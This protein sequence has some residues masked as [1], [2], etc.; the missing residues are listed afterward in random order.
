M[1]ILHLITDHQV[2]ERTLRVYEETFPGCNDV[3]VFYG[4]NTPFKHLEKD[5]KGKIVNYD[6]I[7]EI[8]GNIDFSNVTY[9][10]AHFMSM[11]KIDF[12]K[13]IP[14][15]IHV[16]WEIYGYDLY[17]QF[18]EPQ[19]LKLYYT[20][21]RKYGTLPFLRTYFGDILNLYAALRGVKYRLKR[22]IRKQFKYICNRINSIQCCCGY[23]AKFI[24]DYIKRD[25]PSYE[26][27]NYSLTEVL[28]EL[29][30]IDFFVGSDVLIGNS[31]S[32]SNNHL[33]TLTY[34]KKIKMPSSAKL[35]V[36]LSYG[37][38]PEY[39]NDVESAYKRLFPT[40]V[41]VL[42]EY[43]PLHDYNK[44][45]LRLRS[46]ILSA[47][48]QE[49]Q[50]TAMMGFYLGIKV[51]MSARSPLYKWFVECGF[52]VY[53]LEALTEDELFTPMSIEQKVINRKLVV[54]RYNE[55]KIK[56]IFK[57]NIL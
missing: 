54:D 49:S 37:G 56:E 44:I 16:C 8:A 2:I 52:I 23:D 45:F 11:D 53:A 33:Y 40:H 50:G 29:R 10:I 36:P 38:T 43:M 27:F 51:F 26:V 12:I 17:N 31:A 47:W 57:T 21:P 14:E 42:K 20:D 25:I 15:N 34:L 32:F 55:E 35:I 3:L 28:G 1:K 4:S 24:T 18:L 39:S 48:R 19:G 13:L 5:Y 41:E 22:Q 7:K 6:N 46:I 9:V 30:G